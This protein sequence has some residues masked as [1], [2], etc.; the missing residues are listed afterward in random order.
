MFTS[1]DLLIIVFMVLGGLTLIS[2]GLMFLLKNSKA[3]K[4]CFYI[5]FGLSIFMAY[6]STRI[7]FTALFMPQGILGILIGLVSIASLI[8]E[9]KSSNNS[10]LCIVS[11]VLVTVALIGGLLNAAC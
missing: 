7:G 1:L 2:V 8:L 5:V 10:K 4:I 11:R 3:K 6:V 9:I